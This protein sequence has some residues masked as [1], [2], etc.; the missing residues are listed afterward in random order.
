M[1]REVNTEGKPKPTG[2]DRA[3]DILFSLSGSDYFFNRFFLFRVMTVGVKFGA[4]SK[5]VWA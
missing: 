5:L 4:W 1:G 2:R 3:V